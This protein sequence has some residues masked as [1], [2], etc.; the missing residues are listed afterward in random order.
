MKIQMLLCNFHVLHIFS[1][2]HSS[3]I[4]TSIIVLSSFLLNI[5]E[6]HIKHYI[7]HSTLISLNSKTLRYCPQDHW[8]FLY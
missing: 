8:I 5:K 7:L 2:L 6:Y 3:I 4:N 1:N